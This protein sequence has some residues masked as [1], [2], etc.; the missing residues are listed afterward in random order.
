MSSVSSSWRGAAV[1]R[2][3]GRLPTW[4]P[5]FITAVRVVLHVL[6]GYK[7]G[8]HVLVSLPTVT[9][10]PWAA[11]ITPWGTSGLEGLLLAIALGLRLAVMIACTAPQTR[12]ANPSGCCGPFPEHRMRSGLAVVVSVSVALHK[13]SVQRAPSNPRRGRLGACLPAIALPVLED[14]PRP[15]RCCSLQRWIPAGAM[16]DR[17]I[18]R[19]LAPADLVV[20]PGRAVAQRGGHLRGSRRANRRCSVPPPSCV[21]WRWLSPGYGPVGWEPRTTYRP[22]FWR[23]A[24]WADGLAAGTPPR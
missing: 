2:G 14:Y 11:G 17:R 7:V 5:K 16:G 6:V 13:P 8:D 21:G 18:A 4:L 19:K 20:H 22:D 9:L 24:E 3:R 15:L 1:H 12:F 23:G 10:P